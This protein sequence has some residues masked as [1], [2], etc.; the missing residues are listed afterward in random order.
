MYLI[1]VIGPPVLDAIA[2]PEAAP[3]VKVAVIELTIDFKMKGDV[4]PISFEATNT[5]AALY[6]CLIVSF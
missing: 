1:K 4:V 2:T 6:I 3:A 5:N